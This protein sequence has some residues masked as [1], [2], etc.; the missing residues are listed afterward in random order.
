MFLPVIF[1]SNYKLLALTGYDSSNSKH[2]E[3]IYVIEL[4]ILL[5]CGTGDL[6]IGLEV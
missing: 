4:T 3:M 6:A 1:V 2:R 5:E